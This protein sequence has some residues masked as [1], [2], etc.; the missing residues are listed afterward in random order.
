MAATIRCVGEGGVGYDTLLSATEVGV[1]AFSASP[2]SPVWIG[3]KSCRR[4]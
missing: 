4:G 2:L 1:A 3:P